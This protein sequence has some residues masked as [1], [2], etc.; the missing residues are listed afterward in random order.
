MFTA[1]ATC[2][3]LGVGQGQH[4]LLGL[5]QVGG[6]GLGTC[7]AADVQQ[8][9]PL[10]TQQQLICLLRIHSGHLSIAKDRSHN[11]SKPQ[12]TDSRAGSER[13]GRQKVGEGVH[14][15]CGGNE[16]SPDH[17]PAQPIAG[18]SSCRVARA[19]HRRG[20]TAPGQRLHCV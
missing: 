12:H 7:L 8:G 19:H 1:A 18:P 20:A 14:F 9:H 10:L 15:C 3:H 4:L 5:P 11:T 16:L 13:I 2:S 6:A 17:R